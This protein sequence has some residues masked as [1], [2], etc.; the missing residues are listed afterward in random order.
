M[1]VEEKLRGLGL[2][3][4]LPSV[5]AN[6]CRRAR[7]VVNLDYPAG[8]TP[9][10]G[11]RPQPEYAGVAGRGI[12]PELEKKEVELSGLNIFAALTVEAGILDKVKGGGVQILGCVEVLPTSTVGAGVVNDAS[13]LFVAFC[14][15]GGLTAR[16]ALGTEGRAWKSARFR[17]WS[18]TEKALR[19]AGPLDRLGETGGSVLP[20]PRGPSSETRR[21]ALR[22]GT[23]GHRRTNRGISTGTANL[24]HLGQSEP[25]KTRGSVASA[26]CSSFFPLKDRG[27]REAVVYWIALAASFIERKS[28]PT[29]STG[30][31]R[32]SIV[33][34][35]MSK[36]LRAMLIDPQGNVSEYRTSSC[37]LRVDDLRPEKSFGPWFDL[38]TITEIE[39]VYSV[40]HSAP[41]V[42]GLLSI[43]GGAAV[44]GV[45]GAAVM[46]DISR[47]TAET[48]SATP[49]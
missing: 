4:P 37:G 27:I 16:M 5:P 36:E 46:A 38:G 21:R 14:G 17:K 43:L 31:P 45:A 34:S 39:V 18:P 9:C 12:T 48:S 42:D 25:P 32:R 2:V 20:I 11:S 35:P 22:K 1:T 23:V 44:G 10:I 15:E 30:R 7:R 26:V 40:T 33:T 29:S 13:E 6:V 24:S 28:P 3:L 47:K 19:H 8:R 41:A 49:S